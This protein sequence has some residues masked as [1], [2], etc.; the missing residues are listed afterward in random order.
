MLDNFEYESDVLEFFDIQ[1]LYF[2][3]PLSVEEI[4]E[5][6]TVMIGFSS[7]SQIYFK[8]DVDV[9][10][11]EKIKNLLHLSSSLNDSKIEKIITC[12]LSEEETNYVVNSNYENP[13]TWSISYYRDGNNFLVDT[14]PR[15]REFF[16][17]INKIRNVIRK[18]KLTPLEKIFR[19]YDI[20]KLFDYV[21]DNKTYSFPDIIIDNKTNSKGFNKLF[22]YILNKF[23]IPNYVTTIKG[24]DG[25]KSYITLVAICDSKYK[26]DGYYLFDPSMDS[27]PK[28]SYKDDVRMINYN[29]FGLKLEEFNLNK[30]GDTLTGL[31]QILSISDYEYAKEKISMDKEVKTRR[32]INKMFTLFRSNLDTLYNLMHNVNSIDVNVICNL[33]DNVYGEK[34]RKDYKKIVKSNYLDRKKEL[35]KETLQ[36]KIDKM[37]DKKD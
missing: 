10:S 36:D 3:H 25:K 28:D 21:D 4:N 5:F 12:N 18:E 15:V 9:A 26:I 7:L 14:I 34:I 27:L 23:D 30:Y 8:D 16:G 37:L 20:V 1:N 32:E 17:Y 22:S 19:V 13:D 2:D 31:L 6:K 29:Y 35:F 24:V 33:C 11:I